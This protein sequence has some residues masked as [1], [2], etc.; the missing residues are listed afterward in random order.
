MVKNVRAQIKD[1]IR[2]L[3]RVMKGG[4]GDAYGTYSCITADEI[5]CSIPE[6]RSNFKITSDK[7]LTKIITR[8]DIYKKELENAQFMDEVFK[9]DSANLLFPIEAGSLPVDEKIRAILQNCKNKEQIH[10][11]E[12]AFDKNA[13]IIYILK[14]E[15]G[16][17]S[18]EKLNDTGELQSYSDKDLFNIMD[19]ITN[20]VK[21]LHSKNISHG[22]INPL[23]ITIRNDNGHPKAY[24]IDFGES[25]KNTRDFLTDVRNTIDCIKL[26]ASHIKNDTIRDN[27]RRISPVS[28]FD[29]LINTL[30]ELNAD[31][32]P[33]ARFRELLARGIPF[34]DNP[35][36]PPGSPV[37]DVGMSSQKN[38]PKKR[39]LEM[40]P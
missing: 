21:H 11:G 38:T 30:N 1:L 27:I 31:E 17:E 12:Q 8:K 32:D 10:R 2:D 33:E 24:I 18:L 36:S 19:D 22:D 3:K 28:T 15:N 14:I 35:T 16:G 9:N 13:T 26:I 39:R 29:R 34:A 4:N 5:E 40:T 37:R 23:N 6:W 25:I 7:M 20:G